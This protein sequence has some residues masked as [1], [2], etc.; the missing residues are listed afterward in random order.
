MSGAFTEIV[1]SICV[2]SQQCYSDL[3][4]GCVFGD[5][6]WKGKNMLVAVFFLETEQELA[7]AELSG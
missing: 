3:P 5:D 6:F 1:T 4:A 7:K 2:C